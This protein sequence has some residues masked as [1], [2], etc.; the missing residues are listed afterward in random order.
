MNY[1]H[2]SALK[3]HGNLTSGCCLIDSRWTLKISSFGLYDLKKIRFRSN[4]QD[5]TTGEYEAYRKLLWHAPELL[6]SSLTNS[7]HLILP[8]GSQAGDIYSFGIILWEILHRG[9]PF[10]NSEYSPKGSYL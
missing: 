8:E 6:R 3:F 9:L 7:N 10:Y 2:S 4:V 5:S 1:I